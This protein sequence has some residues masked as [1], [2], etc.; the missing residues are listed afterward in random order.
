MTLGDICKRDV[1]TCR[2]TDTVVAAA[3]FM[4]TFHVGDVVVVA[5]RN[6]HRTPIGILT[7]RDIV[8]SVI[9]QDPADLETLTVADVMSRDLITARETDTL[10]DALERMDLNGIRRLPVV[11]GDGSLTGIVSFDDVLGMVSTE[12]A[13]LARLVNREQRREQV[14]RV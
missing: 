4:R 14:R 2:A 9:A 7:D 1:V 8:V 6:W 12:L 10:E 11:D 3:Q 5:E 13:N